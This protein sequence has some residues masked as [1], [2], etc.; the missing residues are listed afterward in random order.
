M[1]LFKFNWRLWL[2]HKLCVLNAAQLI[3]TH[4]V[5]QLLDLTTTLILTY[6]L[7]TS[8]EVNP[9]MRYVLENPMGVT[10]FITIKLAMCGVIAW[11]IPRSINS[12]HNYSWVWHILALIYFLVVLNNLVHIVTLRVFYT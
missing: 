3:I 2:R 4:T 1:E 5:L 6:N 7:G 8:V 12:F 11:I 9:I 10:F